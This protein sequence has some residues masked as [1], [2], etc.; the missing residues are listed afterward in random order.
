MTIDEFVR[1]IL[2]E[3]VYSVHL[4]GKEDHH[5]CIVV[6]DKC[7]ITVFRQNTEL[8][9]WVRDGFTTIAQVWRLDM[10]VERGIVGVLIAFYVDSLIAT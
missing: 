1:G 5:L 6:V 10:I 9:D 3:M 4:W 8:F 7:K 2:V